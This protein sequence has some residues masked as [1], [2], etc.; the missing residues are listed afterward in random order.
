MGVY[1]TISN[2][3]KKEFIDPAKVGGRSIKIGFVLNCGPLLAWM[4]ATKWRG[5]SVQIVPDSSDHYEEVERYKDVTL[6][7]VAEFNAIFAP[8]SVST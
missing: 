5:D 1:Y 4:M 6:E 7:S 3:T 2:E 8:E